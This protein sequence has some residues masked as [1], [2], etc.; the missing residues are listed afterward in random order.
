MPV[1]QLHSSG[2]IYTQ[3]QSLPNLRNRD[4]WKSKLHRFLNIWHSK[5]KKLYYSL[6]SRQLQ[7]RNRTIKIKNKFEWRKCRHIS[8]HDM[9]RYISR[10]NHNHRQK[11]NLRNA[12]FDPVT[13][14]TI[15]QRTFEPSQSH[16]TFQN[17]LGKRQICDFKESFQKLLLLV[18]WCLR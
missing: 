16:E 18:S 4:T 14:S 1:L 5:R 10:R 15:R 13:C 7:R 6:S 11:Y 12:N 3:R 2:L 8:W 17:H 9:L